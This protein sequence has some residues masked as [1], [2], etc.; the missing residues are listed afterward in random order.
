MVM[1]KKSEIAS[2][3]GINTKPNIYI[4][5]KITNAVTEVV[6]KTARPLRATIMYFVTMWTETMKLANIF[7]NFILSTLQFK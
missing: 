7:E 1:T 3:L 4:L 2:E 6:Q 5:N